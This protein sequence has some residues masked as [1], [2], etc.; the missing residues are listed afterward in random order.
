VHHG[1]R[2]KDARSS[3]AAVLST[4]HR[5]P[6]PAHKAIDLI[7]SRGE[8]AHR[9]RIDATTDEASRR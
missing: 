1:V 9:D 7:D 3:L 8:A 4:V 6:L 5:G 2:I